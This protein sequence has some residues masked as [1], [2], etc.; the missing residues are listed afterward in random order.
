MHGSEIRLYVDNFHELNTPEHDYFYGY[1]G[2]NPETKIVLVA[3]SC[4]QYLEDLMLLL[5]NGIKSN[6]CNWIGL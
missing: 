2:G 1:A 4:G 5:W 6:Y 3:L